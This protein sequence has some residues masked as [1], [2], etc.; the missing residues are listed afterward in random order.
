MPSVAAPKDVNGVED[1]YEYEPVTVGGCGLVAGCVGLISSGTRP[2]NRRFLDASD[3]GGDVFLW[4][5]SR[6]PWI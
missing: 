3:S 4:T 5:S 6:L 1:V 2:R